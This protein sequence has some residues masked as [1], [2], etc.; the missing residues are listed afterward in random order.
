MALCYRCCVSKDV[1]NAL[2]A[3]KLRDVAGGT[4]QKVAF[5]SPSYGSVFRP[6]PIFQRGKALAQVLGPVAK[7]LGRDVGDLENKWRTCLDLCLG[8]LLRE[9]MSNAYSG[10]TEAAAQSGDTGF[11]VE[12]FEG[13]RHADVAV[14]KVVVFGKL[15][16]AW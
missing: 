9:M 4:K 8:N 3:P 2:Q 5:V 13:M 1:W 15:K 7:A 14:F 10:D 11:G 12:D 6:F 16:R